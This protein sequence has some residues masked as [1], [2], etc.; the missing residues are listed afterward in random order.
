MLEK[1]QRYTAVITDL[2]FEGNGVCKIDG[3]TVFVPNNISMI[4]PA[5]TFSDAFAT[6]PLTSTRPLSQASLATVRRLI[7]RETF[8]NLS[9]LIIFSYE[10]TASNVTI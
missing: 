6:F 4:S 2:T 7:R 8:K 9:N 5:L 1:N 10:K 3:M